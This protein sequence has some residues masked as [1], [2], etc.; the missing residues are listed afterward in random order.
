MILLLHRSPGFSSNT[1]SYF[2]DLWAISYCDL[3]PAVSCFRDF[4]HFYLPLFSSNL[5]S[6]ADPCKIFFLVSYHFGF[7]SVVCFCS[8]LLHSVQI[9]LFNETRYSRRNSETSRSSGFFCCCCLINNFT[10]DCFCLYLFIVR[11]FCCM[12][13]LIS[14]P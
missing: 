13:L 1:A 11:V 8:L 10:I 4:M 7:V 3:H 9:E 5:V 2:S 14:F 12:R 6:S